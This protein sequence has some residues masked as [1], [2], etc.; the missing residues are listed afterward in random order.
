MITLEK[1]KA[2]CPLTKNPSPIVDALS[3]WDYSGDGRYNVA[4][5]IAQLAHE[6][7]QFN[8]LEENLNY[9][10]ERLMVIFPK[11]F[12][13]SNTALYS[14]QPQK[15]ANR[16]Y[17]NRMGNGDESSGDGWRFRGR[18]Y[19]MNTGKDAYKKVSNTLF[20]DDTLMI[21]PE[22]LSVPIHAMGGALWFWK[23]RGMDRYSR[24]MLSATK[25]VNGGTNGI[26]DRTKYYKL[27]LS[28][29]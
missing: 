16:V 26:E 8:V 11:Y 2:I 12:N 27:A 19:I 15:I 25:V 9:S 14:R 1:F 5:F 6:S 13:K 28:V 23:S 17:A 24:D 29:L 3:T 20:G 18:G 21:N 10:A 22:K 4:M 7:A